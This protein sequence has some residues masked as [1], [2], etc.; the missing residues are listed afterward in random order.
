MGM[1]VGQ[2][3][4]VYVRYILTLLLVVAKIA[5]TKFIMQKKYRIALANWKG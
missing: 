3:I 2:M 1:L 5:N 4:A